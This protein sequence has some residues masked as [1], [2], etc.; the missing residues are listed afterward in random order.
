MSRRYGK[1]KCYKCVP[2]FIAIDLLQVRMNSIVSQSVP[3]IAYH[4]I[5]EEQGHCLPFISVT[6]KGFVYMFLLN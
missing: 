1:G 6:L 2:T 3:Y 4:F 5:D